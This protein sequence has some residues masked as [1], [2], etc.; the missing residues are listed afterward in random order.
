MSTSANQLPAEIRQVASNPQRFGELTEPHRRELQIHCYRILGSLQEA[1]DMVQE[2]FIK[3]WKRIG[4]YE[5][6]ASFRSW[7]YKIATNN[8]HVPE[9]VVPIR[10][11]GFDTPCYSFHRPA[12]SPHN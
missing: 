6:R 7:L 1:E 5:G 8:L 2:T 11:S 12:R 9:F 10:A 3:A 4:T